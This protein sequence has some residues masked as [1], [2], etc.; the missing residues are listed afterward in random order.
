[1]VS[2]AYPP[3]AN[4]AQPLVLE[5]AVATHLS[6][7]ISNPMLKSTVPIADIR[8]HSQVGSSDILSLFLG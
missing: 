7:N 4:Q 6:S 8:Q 5:L 3:G 1:M 2:T